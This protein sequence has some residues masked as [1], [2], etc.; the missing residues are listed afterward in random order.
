MKLT[1]MLSDILLQPSGVV[2]Q[3]HLGLKALA[4]LFTEIEIKFSLL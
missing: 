4:L 3:F 2:Y 1:H